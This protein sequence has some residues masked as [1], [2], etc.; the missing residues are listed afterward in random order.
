MKVG[1]ESNGKATREYIYEPDGF[2][3]VA[4]LDQDGRLLFFDTD[5]TGLC[6]E[7]SDESGEYVGDID[8]DAFGNPDEIVVECPFRFFGQYYDVE[9]GL[10]SHL[11]RY[12]DP[13]GGGFLS[14]DPIGLLGGLELYGY[15]ANVWRWCDPL[16][17]S[18]CFLDEIDDVLSSA[19]RASKAGSTDTRALQALKKKVDRGNEA[20]SGLAKTQETAEKVIK[21]TLSA[22]NPVVRRKVANGQQVRDVFDQ[23]TGRG[24]RT[25]DGL[26]DTFVNL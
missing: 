17:L 4:S 20:F 23:S 5:S 8:Y 12:Y 21:E 3:P 18:N 26:F 25:K 22:K 10:C 14:V 2:A 11:Y 15:G 24:V 19:R 6:H 9:T 7:V 1:F 13:A 16:G